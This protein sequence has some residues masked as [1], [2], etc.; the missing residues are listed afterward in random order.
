[1]KREKRM[2]PVYSKRYPKIKLGFGTGRRHSFRMKELFAW[3]YFWSTYRDEITW[4]WQRAFR[5]YDDLFVWNVGNRSTDYLIRGLLHMADYGYSLPGNEAWEGKT[6]EEAFELW[7]QRLVEIAEHLYKSR[8]DTKIK[9]KTKKEIEEY[10][11]KQFE[12]GMKKF[13][14]IY[15]DLW[16]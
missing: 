3:K 11:R 10:K 2:K 5:G 4:A 14:E 13:I 8:E 9:N 16:Y 12:T 6:A 15:D 1:M 7:R